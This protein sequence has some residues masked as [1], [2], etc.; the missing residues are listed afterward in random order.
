[1]VQAKTLLEISSLRLTAKR[2]VRSEAK[3]PRLKPSRV[4]PSSKVANAKPVTEAWSALETLR[5]EAEDLDM[6]PRHAIAR[7]IGVLDR[8]AAARR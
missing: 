6:D 5:V 1:M 2:F 3:G 7:A 8:A 4:W